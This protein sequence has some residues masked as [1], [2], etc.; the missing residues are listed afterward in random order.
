MRRLGALGLALMIAASAHAQEPAPGGP[1]TTTVPMGQK[2]RGFAFEAHL[3]T[4]LVA[5]TGSTNLGAFSGGVFAGY[6]I[7]RV[8][9]GLG[10]DVARVASATET[11]ANKTGDAST[12]LFFAPGVRVSIL[13]SADQRVDFFGQFDLGLGG[14][15]NE[16]RPAPMGNQPDVTRFRL[17]YNVGPGVRFWAHPQFAV[18]AVTGVHGDF[19]L[20]KTTTSVGNSSTTVTQTSTVTSI[21]AA[22]QLLG[23]F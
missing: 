1:V 4:Q 7:N 16:Q 17:Y 12:A 23:V 18:G 15:V 11:G 6:K 22:L 19:A 8:I 14:V 20:T 13:R 2:P 10:F 3:G 21:F 5:L 9:L